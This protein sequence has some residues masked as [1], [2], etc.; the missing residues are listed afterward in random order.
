M[1]KYGTDRKVSASSFYRCHWFRLSRPDSVILIKFTNCTII[2]QIQI[3]SWKRR[4]IKS[5][6]A[7][8]KCCKSKESTSS[9]VTS[10][11]SAQLTKPAWKATSAIST[12]QRTQN[13]CG[14]MKRLKAAFSNF[15]SSVEATKVGTNVGQNGG[16]F[17][18]SP[19]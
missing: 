6:V 3:N 1:D 4:E 19:Q 16:V 14:H 18:P 5:N 8:K 13:N 10:Q 17:P 11:Q 9:A 12:A 15:P 7:I 2:S